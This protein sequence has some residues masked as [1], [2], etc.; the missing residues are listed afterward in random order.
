MTAVAERALRGFWAAPL[1]AAALLWAS[2]PPLDLGFLAPAGWAVLLLSLRLRAGASAGRQGFVAAFAFFLPTLSWIAPLV[3]PGWIFTA[4]WCAAFEGLFARCLRPL[5]VAARD[6]GSVAWVLVAPALHLLFDVVRTVLATGFPWA[7]PGYAGWRNPLLLGA[8][9]LLGVH[10]ATFAILVTGAAVAEAAARA[11]ERRPRALRATVPA[12]ATWVLLA[13]WCGLGPAAAER[14]GPTV[15]LLQ[16]AIPQKL[17]E[18]RLREGVRAP[19]PDDLWT[20]HED[21]AAA[22]LAEAASRGV[23]VD[24]VVWPETMVP[25]LFVKPFRTGEVPRAVEY[26]SRDR[27]P[28]DGPARRVAR[29]AAGRPTLAGALTASSAREKFN[30][31]LVL[32]AEGRYVAHQDKQH[33]TP[34]GE[35][36][37]ILEWLPFRERAEAALLEMAGFLPDLRPGDGPALLPFPVRAEDAGAGEVRAGALVCYESIFP[38]IPRAMVRDGADLLVNVSNYGWFAGTAQMEQ[39]L[40]IA[41]FRAAEL[42]RS[43]VLASNNGVSAVIGPDG[44]V[45][46]RTA[47]DETGRLVAEVPLS[48]GE[49]P[50][51]AAGEAGALAVGLV[52]AAVALAARL[53]RRGPGRSGAEGPEVPSSPAS[54]GGGGAAAARDRETS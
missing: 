53:R 41:C 52:G 4:F 47:A 45:R 6:R 36:L 44:T 25:A 11:I 21:L 18:D 49:T 39:A 31:A 23:V 51:A 5:L 9:D 24:L 17:K 22:G 38:E 15:L 10:A 13:A 20:R 19:G 43:V 29:A 1:L 54:S 33:L 7:L 35:S 50:F 42:R 14:P 8:A 12:A 46:A 40:A 34:G 48:G 28:T 27:G 32:D 3:V 37:P 30:S 2:F 26:G 16:A